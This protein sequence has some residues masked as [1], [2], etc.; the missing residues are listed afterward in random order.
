MYE[1]TYVC[2]HSLCI[3]RHAKGTVD[4]DMPS[5]P[6]QAMDILQSHVMD[7]YTYVCLHYAGMSWAG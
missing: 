4:V 3:C 2:L 6:R 5:L 1:C 7:E